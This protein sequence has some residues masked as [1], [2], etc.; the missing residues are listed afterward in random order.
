MTYN[1]FGGTL[2]LAL[3]ISIYLAVWWGIV[4]GLF[5]FEEVKAETKAQKSGSRAFTTE[6]SHFCGLAGCHNMA[7]QW[8]Y[9]RPRSHD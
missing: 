3:S 9:I 7:G 8:L 2:K 1:V 5:F 4:G 6:V